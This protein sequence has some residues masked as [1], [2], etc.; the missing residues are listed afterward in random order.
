QKLP[1]FDMEYRCPTPSGTAVF[2]M[3]VIPVRYMEARVAITH[4]EVT[5]V[6]LSHGRNVGLLQQF[7]L[8]LINAQEDERKRISQEMHDDLGNRIALMA[9]SIRHILKQSSGNSN[10]SVTEMQNLFEQIMDFSSAVRE[11]S[12]GLHPLLLR[13]AGIKAALKSL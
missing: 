10:S 6:Q 3:E 4:T 8:R 5:G 11:L 12:H 7:A 1:S 9:L 13:H 2:R